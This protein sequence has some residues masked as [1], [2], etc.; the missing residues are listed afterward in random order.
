M[1]P[2]VPTHCF[3][4]LRIGAAC[5]PVY[6]PAAT[7]AAMTETL[8]AAENYRSLQGLHLFHAGGSNCSQRARL[9]LIEKGLS[10]ESHIVGLGAGD[11]AS[12]AYQV[13]YPAGLVPLLVHDGKV[14]GDSID[15]LFYVEEQFP[16]QPM[17][18]EGDDE[19]SAVLALV[20]L[21]ADC[22]DAIM[23]LSNEIM[24]ADKS[25]KSA[26][27]LAAFAAS[28]KNEALVRFHTEFSE[29]GKAWKERVQTSHQLLNSAQAEMEQK[30][31]Q[32][33]FLSGKRFG[34]ADIAWAPNAH[35]M[36]HLRIPYG[37]YPHYLDWYTQCRMTENFRAAILDYEPQLEATTPYEG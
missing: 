31:R 18:P 9:M 12:D 3:Y 19:R 21:A 29:N 17:L 32:T 1:S 6:F 14:I 7:N 26:E 5:L 28:H 37:S 33:E 13:M 35:R 22:Q 16:D 11:H 8:T 10:F 15:M 27:D 2:T 20:A 23:T 24:F 36:M 4:R 25:R 34:L 30:L